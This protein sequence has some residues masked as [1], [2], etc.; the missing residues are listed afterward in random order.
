MDD[1]GRTL[2][3]GATPTRSAGRVIVSQ[4]LFEVTESP[5]S[6][7]TGTWLKSRERGTEREREFFLSP[8]FL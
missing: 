7:V 2:L 4:P 3:N 5:L 1:V 6:T 8:V